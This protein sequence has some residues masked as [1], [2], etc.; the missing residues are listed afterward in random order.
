MFFKK[1]ETPI[2]EETVKDIDFV[3]IR[4]Y[5]HAY[6][7]IK[8]FKKQDIIIQF[9]YYRNNPEKVGIDVHIPLPILFEKKKLEDLKDLDIIINR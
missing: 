4:R 1:I 8:I 6:S 3:F 9:T 7:Y 2:T 5:D